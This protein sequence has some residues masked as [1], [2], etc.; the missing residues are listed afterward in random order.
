MRSRRFALVVVLALL[1]GSGAPAPGE[2]HPAEAPDLRI[3]WEKN[4]L[5]ITGNFPGKTIPVNYLE[6]YC[7]PGSTDRD[8][9]ETVIG[10]RTDLVKADEDQKRIRL[11]C[12][13]NDGVVV[14]HE[15]TAS[16]DEVDFRITANNP[17]A[18]GSQAHW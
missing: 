16:A 11:K 7:R 3:H 9:K 5:T 8:W 17:T 2:G 18:R 10:H 13:L 12:T 14:E 1:S 6:A 15:I 4:I